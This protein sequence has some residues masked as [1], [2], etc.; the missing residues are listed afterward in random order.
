MNELQREI[1][2][3]AIADIVR[4]AVSGKDVPSEQALRE[5]AENA[6]KAIAA[7]FSALGV[8]N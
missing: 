7:G 8:A 5:L 4:D 1:A 3:Q 2:A 6:A